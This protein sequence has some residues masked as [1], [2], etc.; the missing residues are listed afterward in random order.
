MEDLQNIYENVHIM[1]KYRKIDSVPNY[2]KFINSYKLNSYYI[3][4]VSNNVVVFCHSDFTSKLAEFR[5][6][7]NH[8]NDSKVNLNEFT[9]IIFISNG[10]FTNTI[11]KQ[12]VQVFKDLIY[13]NPKYK[14]KVTVKHTVEILNH[15]YFVAEIPKGPYSSEHIILNEAEID[16]LLNDAMCKKNNLPKILASDP[17]IV[18]VGGK[19][20]DVVKIVSVSDVVGESITYRMVI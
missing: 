13:E 15:S 10:V 11:I 18:W 9:N 5:N 12:M 4:T 16:V 19:T 2:E 20:G 8:I 1:F 14:D 7:L 6:L 3:E 17:A